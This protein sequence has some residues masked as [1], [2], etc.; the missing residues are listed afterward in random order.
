M[1]RLQKLRVAPVQKRD[2]GYTSNALVHGD[3]LL[4]EVVFLFD[5]FVIAVLHPTDVRLRMR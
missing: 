2:Y 3:W 1:R 5:H 4:V